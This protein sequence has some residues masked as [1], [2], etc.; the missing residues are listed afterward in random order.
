MVQNNHKDIHCSACKVSFAEFFTQMLKIRGNRQNVCYT[1]EKS[2]THFAHSRR[3]LSFS[4]PRF[5]TTHLYQEV[6]FLPITPIVKLFRVL[7]V[8]HTCLPQQLVSHLKC[9]YFLVCH[10]FLLYCQNITH[11]PFLLLSVTCAYFTVRILHTRCIFTL[12]MSQVPTL[13]LEYHTSCKAPLIIYHTLGFCKLEHSLT[14][15]AG[16][17]TTP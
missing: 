12:S 9:F 1:P 16:Q 15:I 4:S 8:Y 2:D 13:L 14:N 6:T 17:N 10:T 3:F 11:V 5:S 7:L